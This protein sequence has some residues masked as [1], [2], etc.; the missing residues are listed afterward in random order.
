MG[1]KIN[2]NT[3]NQYPKGSRVYKEGEPILSIA[4]IIKG[5]VLVHHEGAKY[6]MGP[7]S[8]LAVADIKQ[9]KHQS[10]YTAIE[11]LAIYVFSLDQKDRLDNVLSIN[12]DYNGLFIMSLN[13][14]IN[15]LGQIYQE[16]LKQVR[17]TYYF[18]SD[19]YKLYY[20]SATRLGYAAR[21]PDW[22]DE[23][24]EFDINNELDLEIISYY[25]ECAAIPVDLIKAYYSYSEIITKYHMEEQIEIISQLNNILKAYAE[26]LVFLTTCLVGENDSS[27]FGLIAEYAIEIV[28]NDGNSSEMVDV[29]DNILDII[30]GIK[31]FCD[32]RIGREVHIDRKRMVEAYHLVM[33]GTKDKDM[34]AQAYL[35]YSI[36]DTDRVIKDLAG[37]YQK[38][39]DYAE[40][41]KETAQN[42]QDIMLDFV[43]L[44][45]RLSTDNNA[46]NV[47]KRL[48]MEHYDLYKTVFLKAYKDKKV[49][50]VVDMYL[51]YGYA[52]ERLLTNEQILYLYFLKEEKK[53]DGINVYNIK[54][55]L[56]LIYEGHREPSKN[57]F[58]QEYHEALN[59]LKKRGELTDKQIQGLD[60]DRESKLEFEIQNMFRYN[61]RITSGQITTFVPVLHK[62]LFISGPD[63]T[64]ISPRMVM[65]EL[66]KLIEIDYSIF[67]RE[68]MY[69]NEEKN[70]KREYI[71]KKVYPDI[72]LTPIVG[73]K[74]VMWQEISMKKRSNPG[75]FLFPIF[76]EGNLFSNIVTV[77]GRFRW[78]MCRTIEGIAWNDIKNK[79]LTSEYSDYLQFYRKNRE[80][81][82]EMKGKIK[83]QIQKGRNN[84]REIFV[85]DY[86]TWIDYESKGAIKLN[87]IVREI[88]ATYV[89][90][91][92]TIREQLAGQ[93]IFDDAYA[94]YNRD[95]IK[96]I[97]EIEARHRLLNKDKIKPTKEMEDTLNYYKES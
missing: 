92:K 74:G 96:R 84:S 61:N 8:F 88:M 77:C 94:R 44:K 78:E 5:R 47:R 3:V 75:R 40:I 86:K 73:S 66:E 63:K 76:C 37:S 93:P 20:E 80:L 90:F 15:E 85:I 72:I 26:R 7:G 65:E 69:V 95:L 32:E 12:K 28:N 10:T 48:I 64:Y 2:L 51:K 35:K 27:L 9:G 57:E 53:A 70:I 45:D 91:S 81:S 18:L 56:T 34:S 11:D 1:Q 54:E 49:P 59:S 83:L 22:V 79:S 33:T 89:P 58:D 23:L 31:E 55:W 6:I 38:I 21:R 52:D 41:D 71:V 39:L 42:M 29:M 17:S 24:D 4:L 43:N 87:K 68:V 62:D 97:K 36:E 30:S 67:Q 82:E 60:D 19:Q 25:K 50:R 13:I 16:L 46:R 14:A